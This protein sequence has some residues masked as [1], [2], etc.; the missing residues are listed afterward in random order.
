MDELKQIYRQAMPARIRELEAAL[1]ELRSARADT[2]SAIRRVAHSLRGSGATYGFPEVS[3]AASAVEEA[4]P[5]TLEHSTQQ[6]LAVLRRV[7]HGDV[8][9]GVDAP[10]GAAG[11]ILAVD[12]D[13][14]IQLLLRYLFAGEGREVVFAATAAEAE[15]AL[16]SARF[17]LVLL[18][19]LLP[20]GDGRELLRRLRVDS[21]SRGIPVLVLSGKEGSAARDECLELGADDFLAKPFD[22]ARIRDAVLSRLP[23]ATDRTP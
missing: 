3:A 13:P 22:P 20:D 12:D 23:T 2:E 1:P 19:L 21:R 17:D 5:A 10:G 9:A 8:T 16:A 14:E 18:D 15:S 6:L 11:R 7:A 4:D